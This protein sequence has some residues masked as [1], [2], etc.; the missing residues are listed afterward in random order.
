MARNN[1]ELKPQ[2]TEY[3]NKGKCAPLEKNDLT[4]ILDMTITT[5]VQRL[6][7]PSEYPNTKEGLQAFI[8]KTIDYFE[9]VKAVNENEELEQKLIPD[10]ENWAVY[11][12][13]T[14][15]TIFTYEHR[16]PE[17]HDV[18]AN[19]KNAI[20][21]CKKQ[22]AMTYKIPPMVAVFDLVN[23]HGYVNSN[24]FKLTA[25]VTNEHDTNDIERQLIANG[26]VWNEETQEFEPTEN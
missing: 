20:S 9:Y 15:Q 7:R 23:N 16:T 13:I 24:E 2:R 12:G 1:T 5:S 6:G 25:N 4:A 11:L 18:I 3:K 17:W 26:L 14:R 8:D 21:A 19:F 22:L 10:I